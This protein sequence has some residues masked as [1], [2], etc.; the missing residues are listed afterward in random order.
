MYN[1]YIPGSNGVYKRIPTA[2]T[3]E[4]KT[5]TAESG[6]CSA[7]VRTPP[8]ECRHSHKGSDMGD[9]LVLCIVILLLLD[10]DGEDML[11]ILVAAAAFMFLQ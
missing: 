8:T 3:A 1:R 11:T 4:T 10:S 7:T 5:C 2:E 9:L 6:A